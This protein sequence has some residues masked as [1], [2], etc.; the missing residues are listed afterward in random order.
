MYS[1]QEIR[2]IIDNLTFTKKY[3]SLLN[4]ESHHLSIFDIFFFNSL[5]EMFKMDRYVFF[6]QGFQTCILD[7]INKVSASDIIFF[8]K[9]YQVSHQKKTAQSFLLHKLAQNLILQFIFGEEKNDFGKIIECD[10]FL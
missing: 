2:G 3:F 10:S 9:F 4:E 6:F 1:K 8:R 5:N 7:N